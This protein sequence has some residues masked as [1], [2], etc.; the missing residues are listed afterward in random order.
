MPLYLSHPLYEELF[1]WDAPLSL[2]YS[3]PQ[4]VF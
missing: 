4:D 3:H 1:Q 2:P